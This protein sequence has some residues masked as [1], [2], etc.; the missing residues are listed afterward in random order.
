ML[1]RGIRFLQQHEVNIVIFDHGLPMR[2]FAS[3]LAQVVSS[4]PQ[5]RA[6]LFWLTFNRRLSIHRWAALLHNSVRRS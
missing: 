4:D 6:P 1:I 5:W 2:E 3:T